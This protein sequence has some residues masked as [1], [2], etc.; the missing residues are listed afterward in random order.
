MKIYGA[1]T[2]EFQ[3]D[4]GGG[5]GG[6]GGLQRFRVLASRHRR[7][8]MFPLMSGHARY[9]G[10]GDDVSGSSSDVGDGGI[11]VLPTSPS[12]EDHCRWYRL[13]RRGAALAHPHTYKY[14]SIQ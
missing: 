4:G 2:T 13:R 8:R 5:V 10:G 9:G 14:K 11:T 7:R 1:R 12:Y 3:S 6:I